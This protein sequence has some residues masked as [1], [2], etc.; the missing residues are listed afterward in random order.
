MAVVLR[1]MPDGSISQNLCF[2]LW[3]E[4]EP[5]RNW[6]DKLAEWID[7]DLLRAERLLRGEEQLRQEE[8]QA[9][10]NQLN[11]PEDDVVAI[12]ETDLLDQSG[13]SIYEE[14]LKY[15]L[16][17]VKELKKGCKQ[18]FAQAIGVDATTVSR[19]IKGELSPKTDNVI[20][21]CKFFRPYS[22]TDLKEEPLFLSPSPVD[23]ME[24]RVWLEE[25]VREMS[26]RTIQQL[27]PAL[28]RLLKDL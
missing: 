21:I 6:A 9:I 26:D 28:E 1:P 27:F 18:E 22:Y 20:K 19:W 24:Q 2:L 8:L 3:R 15:L 5:R 7:C 10:A 13:I 17:L 25:R 11:L 12:L 16:R 14:N 23:V 4:D